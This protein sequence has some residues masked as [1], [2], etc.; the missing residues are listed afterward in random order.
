[1]VTAP[2]P[3]N[4]RKWLI[5]IAV[6]VI[7]HLVLI[8]SVQDSFF[9]VFRKSMDDNSGATSARASYPNAIIAVQLDV[10]G[11]EPTVEVTRDTPPTPPKPPTEVPKDQQ[12]DFDAVDLEDLVGDAA[13]TLPAQS[14]GRSTAVP[15]RPVEITWPD[16]EDLGQCLGL[17]I[18]IR[19]QV[20]EDG[21][22]L[23]VE[24]VDNSNPPECT[25]AAMEAAR[26]IRFLPGKI[27]GEAAEMWTRI[28][29]D[30][31]HKS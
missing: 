18:A 7:V 13:S 11:E 14:S 29:I 9:D 22:V 20:G 19:I 27:R 2:E 23:A 6:A 30:F 26:R 1:M 5:I 8:L 31:R 17:R 21:S 28:R 4:R 12:G 16:T 15:P 3:N 25:R 10:E 24:P